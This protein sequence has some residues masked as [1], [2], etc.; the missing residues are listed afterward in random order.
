L[1]PHE[2]N[3]S[4]GIA[5]QRRAPFCPAIQSDLAGPVEINAADARQGREDLRALPADIGKDVRQYRFA[6]LVVRR[7]LGERVSA[8]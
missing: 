4:R 6:F 2:G 8:E 5:D 7:A 3:T 1:P